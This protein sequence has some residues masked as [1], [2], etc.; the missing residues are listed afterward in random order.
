MP[1]SSIKSKPNSA[2]DTVTSKAL[3]GIQPFR[4]ECQ[5][6]APIDNPIVSPADP[7]KSNP[8]ESVPIR[9]YPMRE[10]KAPKRLIDEV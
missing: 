7:V 10:R 1:K 6:P 4:D 9:R 2:E 3:Q 5:Q 8:T